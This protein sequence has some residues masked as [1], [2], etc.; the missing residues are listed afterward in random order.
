MSI[1]RRALIALFLSVPFSSIWAIASLSIAAGKLGTIFPIVCQIWL[2]FLPL[3]WLLWV[4]RKSL[5]IPKIKR[6]D[7]IFGSILGLLMFGGIQAIYWLFT[8]NWI[9]AIEIRNKVQQIGTIDRQ[10][11]LIGCVYFAFINSL[12]EEYFWRWFVYRRCEDLSSDRTAVFLSAFSFTIHHII[13][14]A[15]Y[16]NWQVVIMGSLAVFF[17]GVIWSE[18]YRR[19]RSIWIGYL[20]HAIACLSIYTVA[21]QILFG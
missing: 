13:V 21:W 6:R 19:Y 17:A 12:F 15:A 5:S 2:L 11:F 9:D 20:S 1:R 7:W 10:V 3:V 4:E 14:L 8:K 18:C 16:V